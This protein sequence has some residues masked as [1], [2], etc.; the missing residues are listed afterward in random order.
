MAYPISVVILNYNGARWLTRCLESLQAQSIGSWIEIIVADNLST[1]GSDKLAES[2]V[3][4]L[5]N[6]VFMQHGQNLG[7]CEGNNRA[8]RHATGRFLLFL[9]NDTW[10]EPD[11]LEVLLH[12]VQ[13]VNAQAATPLVLNYDDDS[14]QSLGA[15]GLDLFGLTSTREPFA[16]TREVFMPEGCS[17]LIDRAVFEKLGGFDPVLYM[18]SD[19]MDL[20]WRLWLSGGKAV[21]VPASRLHHRGAA[22]VNPKGLS[23]TGEFRTS[24]TKRFYANRNG[25]LVVA[26]N[27]QGLLLLLLPL[28]CLLLAVEALA[29]LVLVRRWSFIRRA[30]LQAFAA[31][32]RLRGH[33]SA[34]R[35]RIA[36]LRRRSDWWFLRFLRLRPNRWDEVLRMVRFGRPQVTA[37]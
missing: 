24:D 3:Q 14:F 13:A 28:Q 32:W 21:A 2:L 27:A 6:A 7:Y 15:W 12:H 8:A 33:I 31:V 17:Y 34:E 30:Y 5:P 26:K 29:A 4:G 19:E 25:L 23:Q 10:L 18:Y 16:N 37:R 1:D 22:N 11:C 35:R 9:N 36:Q 20:S